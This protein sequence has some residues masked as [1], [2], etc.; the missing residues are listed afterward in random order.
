LKKKNVTGISNDEE[1]D[2]K[3]KSELPFSIEDKLQKSSKYT[4]VKP[5]QVQ[6]VV[7]ERIITA[8]NHCSGHKMGD[9]IIVAVN[10]HVFK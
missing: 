10:K 5:W 8:Q 4:K 9:E 3:I 7:D 2:S 6:V 1:A